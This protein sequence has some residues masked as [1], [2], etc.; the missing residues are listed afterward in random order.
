[1]VV[2][3]EQ[4]QRGVVSYVEKEIGQKATGIKKFGVYFIMPSI[5]RYVA[6]YINKFKGIVPDMFDNDGKLKIDEVYNNSKQAI[7]KSGQFEFMGIIFDETDIDKL[8]THIKN[9]VI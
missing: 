2:N 9:T 7:Q 5:N 3:I 8:Y 4:V 1:M 6:E